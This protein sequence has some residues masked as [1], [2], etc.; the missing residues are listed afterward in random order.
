MSI[1]HTS[2][3]G[4]LTIRKV[5]V[6]PNQGALIWVYY[7]DEI[8]SL[9]KYKLEMSG[10]DYA[11]WGNNDDYLIDWIIKNVASEGVTAVA[12]PVPNFNED[13]P[14]VKQIYKGEPATS[15]TQ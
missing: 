5:E 6:K 10:Q 11:N 4:T 2:T 7:Y 3:G 1:I 15:N 8:Q 14:I 12:P 9:S 13:D